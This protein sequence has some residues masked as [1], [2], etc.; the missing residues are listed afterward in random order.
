LSKLELFQQKIMDG[1]KMSMLD[2]TN[3]SPH[4]HPEENDPDSPSRLSGGLLSEMRGQLT[5][6]KMSSNEPCNISLDG[7]IDLVDDEI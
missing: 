4:L 6:M 1:A 7:G 5:K 3:G 2:K